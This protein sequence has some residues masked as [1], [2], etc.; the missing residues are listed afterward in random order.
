MHIVRLIDGNGRKRRKVDRDSL[1]E[2]TQE[3]AS[4]K[5]EE[6]N[7]KGEKERRHKNE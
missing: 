7:W 3:E 6:E 1:E 2:R 5:G 4:T